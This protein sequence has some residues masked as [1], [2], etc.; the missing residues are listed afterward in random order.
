MC[1]VEN[2]ATFSPP[3]SQPFR[4]TTKYFSLAKSISIGHSKSFDCIVNDDSS[5]SSESKLT[6][7]YLD[8]SQHN[9][10]EYTTPP[11]R[12]LENGDAKSFSL[13]TPKGGCMKGTIIS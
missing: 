10:S 4:A 6:V 7:I 1:F 5:Q 13:G 9:M 2:N 12:T 11:S 8:D 3:I